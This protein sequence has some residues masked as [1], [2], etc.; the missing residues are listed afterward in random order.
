M[1]LAKKITVPTKYLDFANT[2]SKKLAEMFPQQ[3]G[4]NKYVIKLVKGKQPPFKLI[5]N[6]DP[7][8]LKIFMICIKNN[9]ANGFI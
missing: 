9:L 8:E 7:V 1:L 3:T 2:F 6:L 4:I 5:Y